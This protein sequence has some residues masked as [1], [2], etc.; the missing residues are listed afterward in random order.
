[1]TKT[2][3]DHSKHPK[4]IPLLDPVFKVKNLSIH[5]HIH[6]QITNQMFL[7]ISEQA[8]TLFFHAKFAQKDLNLLQSLI[9]YMF[10]FSSGTAP[11]KYST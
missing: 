9:L 7:D 4:E 5:T 10:N 3:H 8:S 6:S 2:N 1:M 11:H